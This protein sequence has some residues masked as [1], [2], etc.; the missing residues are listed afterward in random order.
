V[1]QIR[2][3]VAE[4]ANG[5]VTLMA[6]QLEGDGVAG[7]L[8]QCWGG[9]KLPGGAG[10]SMC[11]GM[12]SVSTEIEALRQAIRSPRVEGA[13][14]SR[15]LAAHTGRRSNRPGTADRGLYP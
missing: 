5:P 8:D 12:S 1:H 3:I 2:D 13:A 4:A 7:H 9:F 14:G 11:F 15:R 6:D 10:P